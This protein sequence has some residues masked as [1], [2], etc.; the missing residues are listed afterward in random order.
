MGE[1]GTVFKK[2]YCCL[3]QRHLREDKN[4]YNCHLFMSWN[5]TKWII[6]LWFKEHVNY[7]VCTCTVHYNKPFC[8]VQG[9]NE[10]YNL[11]QIQLFKLFLKSSIL[12]W[13]LWNVHYWKHN[14]PNHA[15]I[16]LI[17]MYSI[18]VCNTNLISLS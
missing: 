5:V 6:V 4:L 17:I 18:L 7:D 13:F 12:N 10:N 1:S 15:N 8:K 16:H 9:A 3:C 11:I 14:S 2:M